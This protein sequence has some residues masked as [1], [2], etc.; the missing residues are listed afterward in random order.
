M[1]HRLFVLLAFAL[2]LAP[3]SARAESQPVQDYQNELIQKAVG[4][5]LH[6]DR[7]WHLLL[8]Y[9]S[10]WIPGVKSEMDAR[11][12][13][14]AKN[15][16]TDPEAEL[17]AT[18]ERFFEPMPKKPEEQHPQ[19]LF[20]DRYTWLKRKL[21]FDAGRLPERKCEDY[22]AWRKALDPESISL[23]FSSYYMNNPSSMFGHTLLRLNHR[24]H[25]REERLLDYGVNYAANPTTNNAFLYGVLGMTGGFPGSFSNIPY[26]HKV[27]EYSDSESRDL[28]EYD[29]TLSEEEIDRLMLHLW[30][31]GRVHTSY[32]FFDQNCSYMIL[33]LLDVA[34]PSLELAEQFDGLTVIP[35]DTVRGVVSR[36]GLI[37]KVNHRLAIVT[38]IN[39]MRSQLASN[40]QSVFLELAGADDE[41]ESK[42]ALATLAQLPS[43]AQ[44]RVIDVG[45]EYLR[46]RKIKGKDKL[47]P[48]EAG[49]L[50]ELLLVRSGL[51]AP[52]VD[53]SLTPEEMARARPDTGHGTS[54][55]HL[56][57]GYN[58]EN[59]GFAELGYR[60]S[61][62]DLNAW[63]VGY[64]RSAEIELG[65]VNV[66][67]YP[68]DR[69][70]R[71][72]HS[73]LLNVLSLTPLDRV[74]PKMSWAMRLGADPVR[75]FSSGDQTEWIGQLGGGVTL[76]L[77]KGALFYVLGK[78]QLGVSG[79]YQPGYRLGPVATVG[80]L[81]DK[82]DRLSFHLS[83]NYHRPVLG[84]KSEYYAAS[85]ESR[86]SISENSDFRLQYDRYRITHQGKVSFNVYF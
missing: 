84:F 2:A 38:K 36:S 81:F 82:F 41:N 21:G 60:P 49:M 67:Y 74:F 25:G 72:E 86:V 71:L 11:A 4:L 46:Y 61:F 24:S 13:F 32:Y 78:A 34:R 55:V 51:S 20:I 44:A 40:E 54:R 62:H 39:R 8:H 29:L 23:V 43:G 64:P 19:C 53:P 85:A 17:R 7:Y 18:L 79:A 30:A 14:N 47:K 77:G 16:R 10:R 69:R 35:A 59:G 75:D 26:Y 37:G 68:R 76:G 28:W 3:F 6:E 22:Q 48:V 52:V 33:T 42:A 63:S 31:V 27:Q 45:L 73:S 50:K 80:L 57:S 66:R 70:F 5:K 83:G 1:R 58:G 9:R 56:S 15:G 12:F 65:N